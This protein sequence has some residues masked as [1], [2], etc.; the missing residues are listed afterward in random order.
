MNAEINVN[1]SGFDE[2]QKETRK[3]AKYPNI[4]TE[5]GMIYPALG[6]GGEAGEVCEKVKK[7]WR[8]ENCKVDKKFIDGTV[9]EMGDVLWYLSNLATELGVSL[10]LVAR[11]NLIKLKDRL[12][13]NK[14]NG[15]GDNR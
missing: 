6:L 10:E 15:E 3:T 13:R 14:I 5:T 2:Y 9:K 8:D 11:E 7:L 12:E 1:V 4:G